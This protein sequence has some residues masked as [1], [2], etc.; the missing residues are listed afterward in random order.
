MIETLSLPT[1]TLW[2]D[3]RWEVSLRLRSVGSS[4]DNG[5]VQRAAANRLQADENGDHR[6]SVATDGYPFWHSEPAAIL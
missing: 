1:E 5:T 2:K 6:R 3:P 4:A